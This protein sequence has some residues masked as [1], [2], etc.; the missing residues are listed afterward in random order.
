MDEN[1]AEKSKADKGSSPA[2]ANSGGVV[3]AAK[4]PNKAN[5][6]ATAASATEGGEQQTPPNS[7][8][9]SGTKSTPGPSPGPRGWPKGKRRYPKAPGAPKQPLSG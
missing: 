5:G 1:N 8:S 3:E 4:S 7:S 6:T 9:N 2:K